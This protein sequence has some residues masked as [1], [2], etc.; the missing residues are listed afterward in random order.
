MNK[1]KRV[2]GFVIQDN[3]LGIKWHL[4]SEERGTYVFGGIV[5]G[6]MKKLE[7]PENILERVLEGKFYSWLPE[8]K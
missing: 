3:T 1:F 4:F 5:D 6:E 7:M 2:K 8:G